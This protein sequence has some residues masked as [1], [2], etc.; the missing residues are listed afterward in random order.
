ML[1]TA[2]QVP[3]NKDPKAKQK[4][5]INVVLPSPALQ[6]TVLPKQVATLKLPNPNLTAKIGS[7][8]ELVVQLARLY[9]Y[10]GEFKVQ[11][12]LP[13]NAKGVSTDVV[14]VSPGKNEARLIFRVGPEA[15]PMNLPNLVLRAT[16]LVNGNLPT[17]HE[18]KFNLNIVK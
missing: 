4:P 6:L 15:K 5:N 1:R 10:A 3:F 11:A 17:V 14:S 12:V 9:D 2:A 18:A 16:A 8:V 13:P 7:Q